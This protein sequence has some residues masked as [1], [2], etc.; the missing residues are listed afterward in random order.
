MV[1][2]KAGTGTGKSEMAKY[3]IWQLAELKQQDHD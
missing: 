3:L 1:L 2:V